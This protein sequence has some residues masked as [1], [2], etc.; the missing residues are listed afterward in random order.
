MQHIKGFVSIQRYISNTPGIISPVGELS[1][2]SSTYSRERGEYSNAL[3]P[4]YTLTTFSSINAVTRAQIP[5]LDT[6]V[7]L[8]MDLA[9]TISEYADGHV[10]YLPEDLRG[11]L[12]ADYFDR[13]FNFIVSDLTT[14]GESILP[15]WISWETNDTHVQVWFSDPAFAEQY[16]GYEIVVIPPIP[17]LDDLFGFYHLA[18]DQIRA[19]TLMQLSDQIAAAKGTNPE[20]YLRVLTF[21]YIDVLDPRQTTDTSWTVLIY[22]KAGDQIDI[23]KDALIEYALS[24][25]HHTREEWVLIMPE[26]FKR[27]EF[28]ILPRW[29]RIAIPNLTQSSA[30]YSS[31]MDPLECIQW[32]Q[33]HIKTYTE[34]WIQGHMHIVPHD[35]KSIS[36][37]IIDGPDNIEGKTHIQDL[38]SDYVPISTASLDFNRMR[39]T[40]RNWLILLEALLI[41]AETSSASSSSSIDLRR[42]HRNGILYISALYDNVQ[43][44][45]YARS[46]LTVTV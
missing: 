40:T 42:V 5:V 45:V 35:Y 2:W 34:T 29:D 9:K 17:N 32:A 16:E 4:G 14:A 12:M 7:I 19:R 22:G 21:P 31:I 46:N 38:F 1:T 11:R 26:L 44:L 39:V 30:L 23:I 27:T 24:H 28:V 36:M 18:S 8:T 43:Y 3:Y 20:T 37:L 10:S 15:Q 41:E 25:S 6:T 13:A 33:T